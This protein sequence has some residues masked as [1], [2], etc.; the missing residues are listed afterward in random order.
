MKKIETNAIELS[1]LLIRGSVEAQGLRKGVIHLDFFKKLRLKGR[2]LARKKTGF[3]LAFMKEYFGIPEFGKNYFIKVLKEMDIEM[4]ENE[5]FIP[6]ATELTRLLKDWDNT[7]ERVVAGRTE[8]VEKDVFNK[9]LLE[10]LKRIKDWLY[11]GGRERLNRERRILL[12]RMLIDG[13]D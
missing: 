8:S 4:K 6:V 9:K 3:G 10:I 11:D 5:P 13:Y 7:M 2:D 1:Y 12:K